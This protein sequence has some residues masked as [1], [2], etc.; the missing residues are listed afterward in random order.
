MMFEQ[1]RIIVIS[2]IYYS[3]MKECIN[4]NITK[5]RINIIQVFQIMLFRVKFIDK[6]L[7]S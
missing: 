5:L 3:G 2:I 7:I 6:I 1:L 4:S